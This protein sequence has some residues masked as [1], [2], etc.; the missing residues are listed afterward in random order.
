MTLLWRH[1][2]DERVSNHQP[3]SCLLNRLYGRRSKKTQKLRVT[4]FC[5]GNSP[6]TADFPAQMASNAENVSIWWRH[7]EL[8]VSNHSKTQREKST[9]CLICILSRKHCCINSLGRVTHICV[10]YLAIIGSDNYLNHCWNIVHSNL[11]NKLQW[12]LQ[13]TS[14]IFIQEDPFGNVVKKL[15]DILSRP[16]C[17]N[18]TM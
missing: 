3:H 7:H 16:Q 9:W 11:R 15:A 5:A 18:A 14:Y 1:N 8:S 2:G 12:N 6:E 13:R 10:N 17:V 4:G